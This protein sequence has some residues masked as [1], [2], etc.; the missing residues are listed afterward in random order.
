M[1]TGTDVASTRWS[2][3]DVGV[4]DHPAPTRRRR[5]SAGRRAS[6]TRPLRLSIT[7][8]RTGAEVAVE[9]EAVAAGHRRELLRTRSAH[10][11]S[12]V[13][14][15]PSSTKRS[16]HPLVA[17]LVRRQ[18]PQVLVHPVRHQA[19]DRRGPA[20]TAC[21]GCPSTHDSDVFQSSIMSWSS[22]IIALGHDRQ[23][24][25]L[26]VGQPRLV[27]QPGVLLEVG[28]V[29][30]RRDTVVVGRWP[31]RRSTLLPC[32]RRRVVGVHLVA[33]EQQQVGPVVRRLLQH[34]QPVGVAGRR[35][36]GP[37]RRGRARGSTAARAGR[38]RG[39]SRTGSAAA[40]R[41]GCGSRSAGTAS[42]ASGQHRSPSRCTS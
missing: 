4:V 24:P 12:A 41:R 11:V 2:H 5:P 31:R 20:T 15:S 13:V 33:D 1:A 30:E 22:K 37:G 10:A 35:R 27:V 29:V 28:D 8:S 36:R 16:Q 38:R 39:T 7:T 6:S 19:A 23:H 42:S 3:V 17:D 14:A 18:V 21:A 34:A 40:R 32:L 9:A 26:D 25:P